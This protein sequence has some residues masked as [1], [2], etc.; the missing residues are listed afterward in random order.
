MEGYHANL[1]EEVAVIRDDL[2]TAP[3]AFKASKWALE[4]L[5]IRRDILK[6]LI[7]IL[8]HDEACGDI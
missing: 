2:H 8:L 1:S 4:I 3:C 6:A 5:S 7:R